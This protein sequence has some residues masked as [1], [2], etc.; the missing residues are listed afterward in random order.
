M[1]TP[2]SF[3]LFTLLS[4]TLHSTRNQSMCRWLLFTNGLRAR[5]NDEK[6]C[7][8]QKVEAGAT[9]HLILSLRGGRC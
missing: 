6:T 1:L 2:F 4:L 8:E 3:P 9:I 7:S 5:R